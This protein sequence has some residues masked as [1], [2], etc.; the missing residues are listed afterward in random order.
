MARTRTAL[1]DAGCI[2]S[3]RATWKTGTV[4]ILR[5]E[6]GR[7]HPTGATALVEAFDASDAARPPGLLEW[8]LGS[9]PADAGDDVASVTLWDTAEHAFS[10][11][12]EDLASGGTLGR[13]GLAADVSGAEFYEVEADEVRSPG[14]GASFLR[15]VT[16]RLP[17]DVET[18]DPG[19]AAHPPAER[20]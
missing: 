17:A 19:P 11:F 12:G 15:I 1:Y 16:A 9:R 14:T 20:G 6:S 18:E 5:I 7:L 4:N 13:I 3:D 10:A 2:G 8:H